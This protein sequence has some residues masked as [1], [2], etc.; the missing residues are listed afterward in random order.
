MRADDP[1]PSARKRSRPTTAAS[2]LTLRRVAIDTYRENVAY[3][4]RDCPVYRAEVF[5]ALSKVEVRANGQRILA[6]LN[7]VDDPHIVG[8]CELRLSEDAFAQLA[9]A[10]KVQG[11]GVDLFRRLGDALAAGDALYRVHADYPA[12]LEFARQAC[13]QCSAY[14]IGT[15]AVPHGFFE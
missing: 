5:Q 3:M 7:V 15:A 14:T 4:H 8:G 12:D 10:P 13:A 2:R 1:K 6:T 11:A 9:G